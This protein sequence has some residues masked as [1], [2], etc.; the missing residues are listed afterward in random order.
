[1]PSKALRK[2]EG[3]MM[4][5][6][7]RMIATHRDI[8]GGTKGNKGLGHLTKAGVLLLC[9]AWEL[10]D[11]EVLLE[12][13]KHLIDRRKMPDDLPLP[14]QK[15]ISK[16]VRKFN[17]ELKPLELAG[18]GWKDVYREVANGWVNG[19]N[20]PKSTILDQGFNTLLGLEG[21]SQNWSHGAETVDK[22]VSVRGDVAHRGSD[23]GSIHMNVLRD[24]Y[25]VQLSECA[26]QTDNAIT[27][28][29]RQQYSNQ[30][31]PRNRRMLDH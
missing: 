16:Y 20:T 31:V 17:H 28:F 22:F 19:L 24:K 25:Q 23:V 4:R 30:G 27:L 26:V 8:Q 9:A 6:V 10:Y 2:F 12:G 21:L 1:M 3:A 29:I 5:D 18:S 13:V 14:I 15:T 11:D 7:D